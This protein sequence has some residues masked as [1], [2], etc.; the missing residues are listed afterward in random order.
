MKMQIKEMK[1][2]WIPVFDVHDFGIFANSPAPSSAK[3][4]PHPP[5][6][7]VLPSGLRS[8][9]F[10]PVPAIKTIP[11]SGDAVKILPNVSLHT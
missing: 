5:H 2:V 7:N 4:F 9:A 8:R 11:P 10:E 3:K 6:V 1:L